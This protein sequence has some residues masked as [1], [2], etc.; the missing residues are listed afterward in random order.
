MTGKTGGINRRAF[1]RTGGVAAAATGA[2]FLGGKA[3]AYAAGPRELSYI[4]FVNRESVWGKPYDF[5]AKE[6]DRMSGGELKIKYAGGSEVVSGFDAP[7]AIANGVFDM[8]HSANSYY[9]GAMPSSIALASGK[10]TVQQ[11]RDSGALKVYADIVL[12]QVRVKLLGVPLS[13]VG[14]VFETAGRPDHL[15]YFKG[16]KIRS[17]PL[18]DP[19]LVALGATPVTTSPAEAYTALERGIVKGLGWPEIG[20][21]DF[22]FYEQAKYIMSPSFYQ[23]RTA[24]LINPNS[25]NKLPKQLQEV[26]VRASRSA[27]AL[28]ESYAK[29]ERAS[30]FKLMR[31]HGVEWVSLPKDE[32]VRFIKLTED[33][34]WAKIMRLD[35]KAG[36]K[37]KP[38]FQHAA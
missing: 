5:I 15:S 23:L 20:L 1:L 19:I 32:A 8:C 28:G 13:G 38:L 14:Y 10:A 4:A 3:P 34:L 31:K 21:T 16:K 6:V 30:E 2:L 37:L 24:T 33:K 18:Y 29:G 26:L 7:E 12:K 22:K 35:P 17:I 9:S 36:A 11:L 25:F 27:D